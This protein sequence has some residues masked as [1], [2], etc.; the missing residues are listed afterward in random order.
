MKF[1]KR[2]REQIPET[3]AR[4]SVEYKPLKALIKACS[5][6][7]TP[8]FRQQQQ[9][10]RPLVRRNASSRAQDEFLSKLRSEFAK[11]CACYPSW[12]K[13]C[14]DTQVTIQGELFR[15]C[16]CPF[17]ED[18]GDGS[19]AA[20]RHVA[21]QTSL[22]VL[23][24]QQVALCTYLELNWRALRKITKKFDKWVG[25]S[26]GARLLATLR[27]SS[28][29]LDSSRMRS[30]LLATEA[31][32]E[33]AA[34]LR[35]PITASHVRA[36]YADRAVYAVGAFDVA[37]EDA[38]AVLRMEYA[39]RALRC[40]G[41]VVIIGV[42]DGRGGAGRFSGGDGGTPPPFVKRVAVGAARCRVGALSRGSLRA[43]ADVRV[44]K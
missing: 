25:S 27:A 11:V 43:R 40:F 9:S 34:G 35:C 30:Q 39:M 44:A 41:T 42:L 23:Y 37:P 33:C 19:G 36:R 13:F 2:Y 16:Q 24:Q 3:F 7:V 4:E 12:E 5:V 10:A 38:E 8:A 17:E 22:A 6:V 21:L 32:Q 29:L 26:E 20:V 15:L 14:S 1:G 31:M 18:S 28:P